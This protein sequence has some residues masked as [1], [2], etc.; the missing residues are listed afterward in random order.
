MK[1]GFVTTLI[2]VIYYIYGFI[3]DCCTAIVWISMAMRSKKTDSVACL[4]GKTAI[5]TGGN[6][7]IGYATSLLLASRG[8][9]VIIGCRSDAEKEVAQIIEQTGNSNITAKRLDLCSLK[10]V[11]DFANHIKSSE[12][13]IDILINNAGITRRDDIVSPDGLNSV[14]QT[15]YFGHFLL[16]HLLLEPLK[17]SGSARVV[18]LSS[19]AAY[20]HS[21]SLNKLNSTKVNTERS[22]LSIY[23]TN[24]K[25]CA[26]IAAQEFAKKMRKYGIMVNSADPGIAFTPIMDQI[27]DIA[28]R[29][30]FM[31]FTLKSLAGPILKD[32]IEGAQTSFHLV[33]SENLKEETGE[34][35][36]RCR[37]FNK[38]YILRNQKLITN[39]WKRTEELVQLTSTEKLQ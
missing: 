2:D 4:V 1:S 31:K 30:L 15:N 9:R 13:K 35:Y 32:S 16:T 26:I 28:K 33:S 18:F 5:V 38:P 24:S 17:V 14:M 11:R 36:F 8:C 25:V 12:K 20:A 23:Y 34:H 7:G 27:V 10:S 37:R 19:V 3:V 21:L 22:I 39:I 6:S 29:D